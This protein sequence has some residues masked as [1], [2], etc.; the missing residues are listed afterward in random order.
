MN[1][2]GL[3]RVNM[4]NVRY[5]IALERRV[6][7]SGYTDIKYM[8]HLNLAGP[9]DVDKAEFALPQLAIH[10]YWKMHTAF[11]AGRWA[12]QSTS[13]DIYLQRRIQ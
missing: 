10:L 4:M 1:I 7:A 2:A 13:T 11:A 8:V 12:R 3:H 6:F 5:S 9:S